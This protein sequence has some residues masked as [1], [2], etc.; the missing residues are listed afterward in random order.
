MKI[1]EEKKIAIFAGTTEGRLLAERLAGSNVRA[2][3]FVATEYG[4][5]EIPEAPNLHVHDGRID[6]NGMEDLFREKR[7]DLILDATHPFAKAVTA[8]IREAAKKTDTAFLRILRDGGRSGIQIQTLEEIQ[9]MAA[10]R[11]NE[12]VFVD[13]VRTAVE[14]LKMTEGPVFVTTGSKELSAFLELPDW[15]TRVYARVLSMPDVVKTCADMGFYGSHLIA[16]QGPFSEELNVAM[17]RSVHAKWMVTKESGKAGGF[18]EKVSAAKKAGVGLVVIGRP[19]EDGISLEEGIKYLEKN[20]SLAASD[21]HE[22]DDA[23]DRPEQAG[24]S[25]QTGSDPLASST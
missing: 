17:M 8:N 23:D 22:K 16:M 2:D 18:G 12:P 15:E 11:K 10:D 24:E 14:F 9:G 13:S 20:F 25:C 1:E 5:E 3:V 7:Y 4:K 19:A 6:E 21:G